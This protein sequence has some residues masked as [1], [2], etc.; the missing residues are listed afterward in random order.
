M[1]TQLRCHEIGA[2]LQ[3]KSLQYPFHLQ[4]HDFSAQR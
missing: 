1:I 2:E 3:V 4:R